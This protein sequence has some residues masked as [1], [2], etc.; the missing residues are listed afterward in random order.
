MPSYMSINDFKP[1]SSVYS[2]VKLHEDDFITNR[3]QTRKQRI[4]EMSKA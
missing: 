4:H 3:H 1:V 2:S